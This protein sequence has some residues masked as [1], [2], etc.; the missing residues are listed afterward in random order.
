M[1]NLSKKFKISFLF[2]ATLLIGLMYSCKSDEKD[3]LNDE[4][5][6]DMNLEYKRTDI[7]INKL[8]SDIIHEIYD[9]EL[10]KSNQSSGNLVGFVGADIIIDA[11]Q[12]NVVPFDNY[13][14]KNSK[15]EDS[16]WEIYTVCTSEDCVKQK[17]EKLISMSSGKCLKIRIKRNKAKAELFGRQ[18]KCD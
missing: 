12:I 5:K 14:L 18:I 10:P 11:E 16:E 6:L 2:M 3:K 7:D 9:A 8:S 13:S 4:F 15:N 17:I 1:K